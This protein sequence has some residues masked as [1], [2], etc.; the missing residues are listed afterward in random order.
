MIKRLLLLVCLTKQARTRTTS[1]DGKKEEE[2]ND[3]SNSIYACIWILDHV[4][5]YVSSHGWLLLLLQQSFI[6][7]VG[8]SSVGRLPCRG[9]MV[10]CCTCTPRRSLK[11]I[12]GGRRRRGAARHQHGLVLTTNGVAKHGSRPIHGGQVDDDDVPVG[13]G[14]PASAAR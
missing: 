5:Q 6:M 2:E 13:A 10:T 9:S 3:Q 1:G 7:S 14:G 11:T 12:H 8:V 4:L